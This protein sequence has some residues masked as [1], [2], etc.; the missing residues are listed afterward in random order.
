MEKHVTPRITVADQPTE[1]ELPVLK[2]E[3]FTGVVNLRNPGEPD[4]PMDPEDEGQRIRALG[5]D[6]LHLGV[7]SVPLTEGLVAQLQGFL[8][9][10][11]KGKVLVH[12]RKGSRAANMVLLHFALAEGWKP[13]ELEAKGKAMGLEVERGPLTLV[14]NYLRAQQPAS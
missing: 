2:Q 3:G 11:A 10:H 4:Q 12:C 9:Q 6:Y 7:S 13:S 14:E 1:A 8:D 5:M